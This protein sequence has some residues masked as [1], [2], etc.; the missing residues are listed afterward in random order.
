MTESISFGRKLK[1]G[2]AA[3]LL[4]I[5]AIGFLLGALLLASWSA[6]LLLGVMAAIGVIALPLAWLLKKLFSRG[7][8]ASKSHAFA[9]SWMV[10]VLLITSLLTFPYFYFAVKSETNPLVLPQA[11]L[12]DGEKTVVFQGMVHVGSES[13]YKSVVYDL[14]A[15]L[16]EGYK[17]YYEGVMPSTEEANQWFS[18]TISGGASLTDNYRILADVCGV[19]FQLDYFQLLIQDIQ[20]HPDRHATVDVSTADLKAE[21]ERLLKE[22][23]EFAAAVARESDNKKKEELLS[24]ENAGK[25]YAFVQQAN[26][27][28]KNIIG[29][30]CRGFFVYALKPGNNKAASTLDPLLLDFRNNHLARQIQAD[31]SNKIYIT[32]GAGHLPGLIQ[33]LQKSNPQWEVKSLKW[34]RG[35]AA[36]EHLEGQLQAV[37]H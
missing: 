7:H 35:M 6:W 4:F 13:F 3:I 31:T 11:V 27:S 20:A 1:I 10:S 26:D 33:R 25:I 9:K 8:A 18:Q 29:T 15:A 21:Y 30:V 22:S 24:D 12:S 28:Q 19:K 17:I 14:E 36:P 16:N 5:L 23:P 32:Y 37:S 34:L 2:I